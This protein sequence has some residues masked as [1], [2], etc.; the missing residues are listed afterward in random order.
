MIIIKTMKLML[1]ITIFIILNVIKPIEAIS[2]VTD[3]DG[4]TYSTV[5]IGEQIWMAENLCVEH[6]RN[7]DII[8]QVQ[9]PNEWQSL[10]KG[11][12]C[13]YQNNS[14]YG[15]VFGKL[16]NF[17][18]VNDSRGLAPEG[19]RVSTDKDWDNLLEYISSIR[20]GNEEQSNYLKSQNLWKISDIKCNESGF[21]VL[22]VGIRSSKGKFWGFTELAIFWTST[23]L[24]NDKALFR[25]FFY[26]DNYISSGSNYNNTGCNIRCI[27]IK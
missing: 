12:W 16:Y 23:G 26:N 1:F 24:K 8:P 15:I 21:S 14:E 19:W 2:Q 10:T 9:D 13:Y 22:P 25:E 27:K 11:A 5:I 7:G 3:I 6:Y 17:Y 20:F 4:I 18:A